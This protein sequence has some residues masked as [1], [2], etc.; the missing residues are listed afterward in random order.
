MLDEIDTT[1]APLDCGRL[2]DL[3][4]DNPQQVQDLLSTLMP[5]DV[6]AQAAAYAAYL[7]ERHNRM[8][9]AGLVLTAWLR[10]GVISRER[11]QAVLRQRQETRP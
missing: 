11:A 3:L 1:V 5:T 10:S 4:G 7:N 6:Y 8:T 2:F 9:N